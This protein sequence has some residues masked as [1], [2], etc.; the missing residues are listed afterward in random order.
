MNNNFLNRQSVHSKSNKIYDTIT[1]AMIELL[2]SLKTNPER[3]E[4][5]WIL[6]ENG[7]GAHNAISKRSYSGVNQLF[8]SYLCLNHNY[9][10]NRWLTF[11]Q[12]HDLG[13]KVK[14]DEKASIIVFTK[15]ILINET[16]ESKNLAEEGSTVESSKT[17]Y[18][19][20]LNY[21]NVFNVDQCEGIGEAFYL[22]YTKEIEELHP[23]EVNEEIIRKC[24]ADIQFSEQDK[25][26][27]TLGLDII[28]MPLRSQFKS[29]SGFYQT[30]FHETGHWTGHPSRLNRKLF[31]M[32]GSEDY[33]REELT[34]E[35]CSV[36]I[37]SLSGIDIQIKQ[38]A[39]Y[40]DSW[41]KAIKIDKTAFIRSAMQAQTAAN[42][43]LER[44][45]MQYLKN[46]PQEEVKAEPET[47]AA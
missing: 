11:N 34:A 7:S 15:K 25:A 12:V 35:L 42:Y 14:K 23:V 3:W 17:R 16:E 2:E 30:I 9:K 4:K 39:S 22:P 10:F 45:G 27:Y 38:S 20:L 26:F 13:G 33:A 32:F 40:I 18:K 43:I 19:F 46:Q 8:L 36:F 28:S 29:V 24:G 21:Y 44:S 41:L 31:N 37:N 6:S 1:N 5:P 47:V